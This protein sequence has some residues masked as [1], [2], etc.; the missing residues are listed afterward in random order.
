[1]EEKIDCDFVD[2]NMGC[3]IDLIYRWVVTST[4]KAGPPSLTSVFCRQG[5]G[6]GLMGGP[7]MM[8]G[9]GFR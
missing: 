4:H 8:A 5:M 2:I 3:P 1:M 6:A 9:G 7:G